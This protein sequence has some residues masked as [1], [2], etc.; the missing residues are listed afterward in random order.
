MDLVQ[1]IGVRPHVAC[2]SA[3]IA[4]RGSDRGI[5]VLLCVIEGAVEVVF[6]QPP[7]L[8]DIR[9]MYS[10]RVALVVRAMEV[11]SQSTH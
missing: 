2:A 3:A 8:E 9:H 5:Y 7:S 4:E 10:R 1:S 11:V 6:S